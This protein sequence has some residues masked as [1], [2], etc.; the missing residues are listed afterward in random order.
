MRKNFSG[1]TL[2]ELL[3]VLAIIGILA[4]LLLT[5]VSKTK[6]RAQRIH[7]ANNERQLGQALQ[8]FVTDKHSYPLTAID[9]PDHYIGWE[10]SLAQAELEGPG[11]NFPVHYPPPGIWH[12]PAAYLPVGPIYSETFP[13]YGYNANGMTVATDTNSLGLGGHHLWISDQQ[14]PAP[15]VNEAEVASPSAMMAIG[16]G[17]KGGNPVILDGWPYLW[18]T[19]GLQE[20]GA[21]AGSTK[22]VNSR[23][24]GRANVVFCDGHVES[25]TL[26]YLFSDT[27]DEALSRWNRDHQPHRDKL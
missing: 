19:D 21:L 22:R 8:M 16:D 11:H 24:Q 6:G 4:A 20:T 15:P 17:F 14:Q 9:F 12:C 26:Q 25:P 1:F 18:R 5:A 13:D 2:T 10:N 27:S 3:V 23:H 7:C